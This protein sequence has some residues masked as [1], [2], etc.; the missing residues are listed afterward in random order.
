[1]TQRRYTVDEVDAVVP[2]LARRFETVMQLRTQL[3]SLYTRLDDG[4]HP[5]GQ[6]LPE[7]VDAQT[8]RDRAVFDGMAETLRDEVSAIGASG[9]VI[10]DVEIGLVDWLGVAADGREVWLCWRYGEP[11]LGY[12]HELD[13]GFSGRRPIAELARA[14]VRGG[15]GAAGPPP[16]RG[17][18]D[19]EETDS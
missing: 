13:T 18:P 10:R 8:V 1:M 9:C 11:A 2:E 5:P 7:G 3:K 6:T 19:P 14:G 16:A 12:F 15:A 4:G 17:A